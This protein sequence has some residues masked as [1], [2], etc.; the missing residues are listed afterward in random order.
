MPKMN[1]YNLV[2]IENTDSIF[3]MNE[4]EIK[5]ELKLKK[6]KINFDKLFPAPN[7]T[8]KNTCFDYHEKKGMFTE[9]F[10]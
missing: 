9:E 5:E 10:F 4:K 6:K 3:N 8:K 2:D 1:G 7:C